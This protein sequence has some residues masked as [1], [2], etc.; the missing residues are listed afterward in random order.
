M[1]LR[2]HTLWTW[3]WTLQILS[4]KRILALSNHEVYGIKSK[5]KMISPQQKQTNTNNIHLFV[6]SKPWEFD[7][8]YIPHVG[9]HISCWATWIHFHLSCTILGGSKKTTP[10][11]SNQSI[12]FINLG[13]KYC[14][15]W[16]KPC[17]V[18][19]PQNPKS[20][21]FKFRF[22]L[23]LPAGHQFLEVP[24][25]NLP[26]KSTNDHISTCISLIF[27]GFSWIGKYIVRPMDPMG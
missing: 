24:T 14:E 22:T 19:D 12:Y 6:T 25:L 9:T 21:S 13:K 23:P 20:W 15:K 17:A 27:Y 16:T 1:L 5:L 2:F 10:A 7:A 4:D 11:Q 26:I 18:M 3:H 8:C